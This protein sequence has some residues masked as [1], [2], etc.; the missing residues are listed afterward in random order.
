VVVASLSFA[1]IMQI[2]VNECSLKKVNRPVMTLA[3]YANCV[4]PVCCSLRSCQLW[5]YHMDLPFRPFV[6]GASLSFALIMHVH[7]HAVCG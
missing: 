5:A 1:L 2:V 4:L 6:G 7:I 3:I